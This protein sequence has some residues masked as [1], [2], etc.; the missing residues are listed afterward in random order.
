MC[1]K[2]NTQVKMFVA[3]LEA[4][5]NTVNDKAVNHKKTLNIRILK[6]F[7]VARPRFE[8]GTSGL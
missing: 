4:I 3:I 8:L 1:M 6:G 5:W 2:S 7:K